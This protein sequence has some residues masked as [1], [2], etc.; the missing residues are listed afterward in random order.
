MM[1]PLKVVAAGALELEV[2]EEDQ[3]W[4]DAQVLPVVPL[5]AEPIS[6]VEALLVVPVMSVARSFAAA[7]LLVVAV[8]SVARSV[9]VALLLVVV[10]S[11]VVP[12]CEVV[13]PL[14][15]LG[16]GAGDGAAGVGAFR[17]VSG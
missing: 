7:L 4:S 2:F 5:L 14:P 15:D 16:G 6:V 11:S 17:L 13:G 9:V 3:L 8:M 12:S 10:A 1:P